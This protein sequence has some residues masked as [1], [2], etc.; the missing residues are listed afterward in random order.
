MKTSPVLSEYTEAKIAA[1]IERF[2]TKPIEAHI[3][4]SLEG[5]DFLVHC[6]V[7]GGDGFNFQVEAQSNHMNTAIDRMADKVEALLKKQKEKIKRHHQ[8]HQTDEGGISL[9][10]AQHESKF[11]A[12][13]E[14]EAAID[15]EDLIK[16]EKARLRPAS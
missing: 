15:A 16:Y 4:F 12:E 8:P 2:A 9:V 14:D 10:L 13:N 11:V 7:M 1:K 3:T 6:N 5:K